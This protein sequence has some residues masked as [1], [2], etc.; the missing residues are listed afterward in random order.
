MERV[1]ELTKQTFSKEFLKLLPKVTEVSEI[2][3]FLFKAG[4]SVQSDIIS[5]RFPS[6]KEDK[7]KL[8]GTGVVETNG[9]LIVFNE[10]FEEKLLNK[11]LAN[12]NISDITQILLEDY[13]DRLIENFGLGGF[14]DPLSAT[15]SAVIVSSTP[16]KPTF[17]NRVLRISDK[18]LG[19]SK[20]EGVLGNP[21]LILNSYLRYLE[22]VEPISNFGLVL[23]EKAKE[24]VQSNKDLLDI[25]SSE[26]KEIPKPKPEKTIEEMKPEK[27]PKSKK[28]VKETTPEIAILD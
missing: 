1:V 8:V 19:E 5:A 26:I 7:W 12:I 20:P 25:Y 21:Q 3:W 10:R 28:E 27:I 14:V 17:L 6:F 15:L 16:E 11:D 2:L 23:S 4:G 18:F 9:D 13:P 22:L 24:L